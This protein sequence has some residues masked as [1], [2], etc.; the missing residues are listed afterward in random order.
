MFPGRGLFTYPGDKMRTQIVVKLDEKEVREAVHEAAKKCLKDSLVAVEIEFIIN[1]DKGV[2][3][4][5][6]TFNGTK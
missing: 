2:Q 5:I 6:V 3:G 1:G 4:A